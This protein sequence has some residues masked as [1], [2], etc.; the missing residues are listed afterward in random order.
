M[1]EDDKNARPE[2]PARPTPPAAPPKPAE[3]PDIIF[4][5]GRDPVE[6]PG[7]GRGPLIEKRK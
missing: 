4:K 6:R 3:P 2:I 1:P 7:A 5:G